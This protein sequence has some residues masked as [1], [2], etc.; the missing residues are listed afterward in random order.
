MPESLA[1]PTPRDLAAM[2]AAAGLAAEPAAAAAA[3]SFDRHTWEQA[4]RY[5]TLH[6]YSRL[7]AMMLAH[8]ANGSGHIP[9]SDV[10]V[11]ARLAKACGIPQQDAHISL[12]VLYRERYIDRGP[13]GGHSPRSVTLTLPPSY[14]PPHPG[15][16]S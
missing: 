8:Y 15:R 1:R 3:R 7:L 16:W 12:A 14:R 11:A 10:L 13:T 6:P 9:S 4:I 5:S 2:P